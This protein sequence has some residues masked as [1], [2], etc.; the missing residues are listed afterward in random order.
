MEVQLKFNLGDVL[1]MHKTYQYQCVQCKKTYAGISS[2]TDNK[3]IL[4]QIPYENFSN[5]SCVLIAY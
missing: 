4:R 3:E 5:F 2:K 1:H